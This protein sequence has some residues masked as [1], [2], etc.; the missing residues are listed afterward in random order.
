MSGSTLYALRDRRAVSRTSSQR[1]GVTD[2]ARYRREFSKAFTCE[3]KAIAQPNVI[4]TDEGLSGLFGDEIDR[5]GQLLKPLFENIRIVVYLRR[6]DE[7][8]VSRYI[9]TL[10]DG[11]HDHH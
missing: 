1:R 5:L 2:P 9:Q 11:R 7:H 3:I 6:Q 4:L 8:V 10:S